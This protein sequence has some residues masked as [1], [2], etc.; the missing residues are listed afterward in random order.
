M[1][2]TPYPSH[3][4]HPLTNCNDLR[5]PPR[6]QLDN[7]RNPSGTRAGALHPRAAAQGAASEVLLSERHERASDVLKSVFYSEAEL[8]SSPE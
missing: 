3:D 5:L 7:P 2:S 6:R 8:Q 1:Q 4:S